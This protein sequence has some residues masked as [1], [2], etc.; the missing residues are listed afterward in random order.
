MKRILLSLIIL[1]NVASAAHTNTLAMSCLTEASMNGF[2]K[3]VVNAGYVAAIREYMGVCMIIGK[4]TEVR[5]IDRTWSLVKVYY[6]DDVHQKY[7]TA[8]T[9][10]EFID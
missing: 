10:R 2:T 3:I 8:W 5:I 9:P 7:R 6:Y 4:N 1:G